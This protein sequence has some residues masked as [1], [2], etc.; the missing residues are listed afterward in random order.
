MQ[1]TLCISQFFQN[2]QSVNYIQLKLKL[3]HFIWNG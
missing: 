2:I 3:E 1:N